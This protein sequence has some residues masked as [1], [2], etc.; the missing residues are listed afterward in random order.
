MN[1][2]PVIVFVPG[3]PAPQGSKR[4][5]GNGRLI[6]SSK[7]VA[8]W[9]KA[10]RAALINSYHPRYFPIF[11]RETPVLAE[12]IFTLPAPKSLPKRRPVWPVRYPDLDKLV[13]S[14]FDAISLSGVWVDDAQVIRVIAEK[15]YPYDTLTASRGANVA[16]GVHIVL[17]QAGGLL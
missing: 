2:P 17:S 10:V 1:A 4:H 16:T 5:V 9:R 6:E 14:T 15:T 7:K 13:R 8:P 12:L 11:D 3:I